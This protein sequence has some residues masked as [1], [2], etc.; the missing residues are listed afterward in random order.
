MGEEGM[1]EGGQS[2][3]LGVPWTPGGSVVLLQSPGTGSLEDLV[4]CM[5]WRGGKSYS[6]IS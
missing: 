2:E 3:E 1:G 4:P 5:K 6:H